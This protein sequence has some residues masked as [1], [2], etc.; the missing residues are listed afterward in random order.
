MFQA[1]T[2]EFAYNALQE[3]L[4]F[5]I[6]EGTELQGQLWF[7]P[8]EQLES[9]DSYRGA[10]VF[11]VEPDKLGPLASDIVSR[12]PSLKETLYF[13]PPSAV[14]AFRAAFPF[15]FSTSASS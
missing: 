8:V 6:E 2:I 14:D 10:V 5:L 4:L 1:C 12:W 9:P 3:G 13:L 11:G 15:C 7:T